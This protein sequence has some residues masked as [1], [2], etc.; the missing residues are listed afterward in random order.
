MKNVG[1]VFPLIIYSPPRI[2]CSRDDAVELSFDY[3][4]AFTSEIFQPLSVC[5]G[6]MPTLVIN[7]SFGLQGYGGSRH[8]GAA[9]AQHQCYKLMRQRQI[10]AHTT[11]MAHQ[12]PTRK[13][14]F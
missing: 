2:F 10:L 11:V 3:S 13:A 7:V 9:H 6:D 1:F 8:T 5:D 12:Q 14:F 4:V